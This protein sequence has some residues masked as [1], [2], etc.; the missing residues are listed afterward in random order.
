MGAVLIQTGY[1]HQQATKPETLGYSLSDSPVGLCAWLSEKFQSWP[2]PSLPIEEKFSM[3]DI[4]T[5]CMI[6]WITNSITS[7]MRLYKEQFR[8]TEANAVASLKVNIPVALSLFP[9]EI[10]PSADSLIQRKFSNIKLFHKHQK[11]GH[12]AALEQPEPL[13]QDLVEFVILMEHKDS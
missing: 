12:F 10:F 9:H 13:L 3:D 1:F 5:N 4:L 8:T 6:Y 2:D 11:G 7:S